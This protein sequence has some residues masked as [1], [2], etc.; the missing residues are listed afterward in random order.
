MSISTGDY[1]AVYELRAQ[2]IDFSGYGDGIWMQ[3]EVFV[4]STS[5]FVRRANEEEML[6]GCALHDG[7]GR[8]K[9]LKRERNASRR[10]RSLYELSRRYFAPLFLSERVLKGP[11]SAHLLLRRE[12]CVA[13]D[14]CNGIGKSLKI[15][16]PRGPF[17]F[18]S[19]PPFPISFAFCLGIVF[20]FL[21]FFRFS[22]A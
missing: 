13:K 1:D 15:L 6:E 14:A 4:E 3:V 21:P 11:S 22:R 10:L 7:Q 17:F 2:C 9:T 8:G 18:F 19:A 12:G 20:S 5:P 16:N